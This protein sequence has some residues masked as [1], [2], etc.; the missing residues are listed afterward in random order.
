MEELAADISTEMTGTRAVLGAV[1]S[2]QEQWDKQEKGRVSVCSY[3]ICFAITACVV[4]S[5]IEAAVQ[6]RCVM[7]K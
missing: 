2:Q 7:L 1:E 5:S 6:L 3:S 4:D